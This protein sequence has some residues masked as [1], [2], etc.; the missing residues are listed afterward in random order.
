MIMTTKE[1]KGENVM[2]YAKLKNPEEQKL[3]EYEL[4][5][6]KDRN[7]YRRLT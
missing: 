3:L 6:A 4:K 2:I 5:S 1:S 7:W